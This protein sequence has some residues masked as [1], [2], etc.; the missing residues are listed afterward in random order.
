MIEALIHID[1]TCF[2]FI[3]TVLSNPVFDFIMPIFDETK[4]FIPILLIPWLIAL[5]Y[6]KKNR[7][8][9]AVFIPLII[10][11]ADQSGLLIKK[12]VLRPRPWAS[13]DPEIINHL[14]SQKGQFY[15]FPSNHAAN[16]SGLAMVFSCIYQQYKSLFWSLAIMVMF[17][18]VYI[19]VHYP[20]DVVAG[21]LI[22]VVYG[23]VISKTWDYFNQ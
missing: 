6:D 7:W 10:L 19:G 16:T 23:L 15:S 14:V 1:R 3:N 18:R 12:T 21:C 5:I 20:S 11:L 4:Y 13:L 22:G 9:L 17:S 2:L 8:K